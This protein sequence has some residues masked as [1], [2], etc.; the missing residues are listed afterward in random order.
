MEKN[1]AQQ[2]TIVDNAIKWVK[3]TDSMRGAKGDSAYRQLV[4]F[5]RTLKK[6]KYAMEGNPAAAI[7]GASQMGNPT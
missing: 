4:G 7:Y 6:K 3:E 1:I 5:R 2:L